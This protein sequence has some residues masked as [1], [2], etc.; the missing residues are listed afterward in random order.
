MGVLVQQLYEKFNFSFLLVP[1]LV[2]A[3]YNNLQLENTQI[4]F[5]KVYTV[6]SLKTSDIEK[7]LL[8]GVPILKEV[9][10]FQKS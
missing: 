1:F 2:H 5:E 6:D 9:T 8:T 3:Q 4:F 10:G 7:L